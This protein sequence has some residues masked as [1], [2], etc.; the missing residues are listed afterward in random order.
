MIFF[1]KGLK[2]RR[3]D[4]TEFQSNCRVASQTVLGNTKNNE[5]AF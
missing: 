3:M 5:R 2:E 1:F 4:I